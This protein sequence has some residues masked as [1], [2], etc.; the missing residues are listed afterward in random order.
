MS[1]IYVTDPYDGPGNSSSCYRYEQDGDKVTKYRVTCSKFFN[2]E[3]NVKQK[4]VTEVD[5]W[6]IHDSD[7]PDWLNQYLE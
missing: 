1:V 7:M 6:D 4:D 3:E 2:G 5:S